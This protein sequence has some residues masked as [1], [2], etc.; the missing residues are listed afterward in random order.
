MK[1]TLIIYRHG[2]TVDY[3][4]QNVADVKLS[5]LGQQQAGQLQD[6]CDLL[7]ISNLRRSMET[8]TNS[9]IKAKDHIIEKLFREHMDT[10]KRNYLVSE[11]IRKESSKEIKERAL[12]ARNFILHRTNQTIVIITHFLFI[13]Y[14]LQPFRTTAT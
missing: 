6:E 3:S 14:L 4:K 2:N 5:K 8:Y 10:N 12:A 1:K 13:R 7:I 11:E 9:Q